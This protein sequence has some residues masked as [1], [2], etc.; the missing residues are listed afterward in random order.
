MNRF[1]PLLLSLIGVLFTPAWAT[2]LD[3]RA[4]M[5]KVKDRDTGN[6]AVMDMEMILID[7]K[8]NRRQRL[9]RS[10]RRDAPDHP[11]DSQSILFFL[12]PAN[13]K[14]T[15]FLTYD[16]DAPDRDD[17]QWLY[18]PAL[19]KVKRIAAADKSGSFMGS[20]FS[21]ADMSTPNLD[22]YRY[23]VMK[24]VEIDG[25][26]AWQIKSTPLNEA[27]I[28]R[29]GYTQA[30]VFVRQDNFVVIRAVNWVR[31]GNKLKYMEIKS[32]E[33]IDGIWTGT[34]MVMSTKVGKV[35][36][37]ASILRMRDVKYGQPLDD[38]LFSQRRLSHG[39]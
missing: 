4:I 32:L 37:H 39:P 1:I 17:D 15:G 6:N 24:E 26:K 36:E 30:V 21:Y 38:E 22:D 18:L 2:P 13:V 19:K 7:A 11:E 14:D 16:Y 31:Q 28:V 20:D 29:T 34:E 10:Y 3:G 27:E 12:E 23:E 9:L 35:T 5:Q 8:G 33:Q 25:H